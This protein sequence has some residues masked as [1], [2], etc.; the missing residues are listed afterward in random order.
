M[1]GFQALH[2]P[3]PI[4]LLNMTLTHYASSVALSSEVFTEGVIK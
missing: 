4:C 3:R 2:L 1:F